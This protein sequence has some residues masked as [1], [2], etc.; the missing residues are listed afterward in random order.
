MNMPIWINNADSAIDGNGKT[1][2]KLRSKGNAILN[3]NAQ[4]LI[5]PEQGIIEYIRDAF[6]EITL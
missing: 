3:R 6:M 1:D 2:N 4:G 5:T